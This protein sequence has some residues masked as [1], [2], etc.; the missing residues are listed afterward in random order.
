MRALLHST[1]YI[2]HFIFLLFYNLL[3]IRKIFPS[4]F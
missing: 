4:G 2:L 3:H 1:F